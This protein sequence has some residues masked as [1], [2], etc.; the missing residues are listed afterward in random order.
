MDNCL[1]SWH[2]GSASHL[3]EARCN[4]WLNP[5]RHRALRAATSSR[6]SRAAGWWRIPTLTSSSRMRC[7]LISPRV[8]LNEMPSVDVFTNGAAAESNKRF[9]LRSHV[10][11]ADPRVSSAWKAA[12]EECNASMGNLLAHAAGP[13]GRPPAA[14]VPGFPLALCPAG[15]A[16]RRSARAEGPQ[17]ARDRRRRPDGHQYAGA[18]RR[19]VGARAASRQARQ[20]DFRPAV[21]ARARTTIRPAA[22][23]SFTLHGAAT[24]RS[25]SATTRPGRTSSWCGAIPTAT[26]C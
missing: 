18:L 24:S 3:G 22:S 15:Q 7:R 23:S 5:F 10:V 20:A 11:L 2:R 8:L 4:R 26:T 1:A 16:A 6:R 19:H 25:T 9:Y 21:P 13:H 12:I 14:R 17:A